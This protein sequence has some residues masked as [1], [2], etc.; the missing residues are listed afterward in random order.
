MKQLLVALRRPD[1]LFKGTGSTRGKTK[2]L[3]RAQLFVSLE[4]AQAVID[5]HP[6]EGYKIVA[7][8]LELEEP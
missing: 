3:A 6:H 1:G 2:Y 5:A 4:D 7:L 8:E